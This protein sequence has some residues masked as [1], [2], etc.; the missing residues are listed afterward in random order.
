MA[1]PI[2][3][4]ALLGPDMHLYM[5]RLPI[6]PFAPNRNACEKSPT[7]PGL[8]IVRSVLPMML[9]GECG[10]WHVNKSRDNVMTNM[11]GVVVSV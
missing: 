9:V 3:P 7:S 1:R 11:W 6:L 2:P 8:E 5:W 4:M 10:T